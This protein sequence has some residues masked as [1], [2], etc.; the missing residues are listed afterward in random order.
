[1]V[2]DKLSTRRNLYEGLGYPSIN[3]STPDPPKHQ[4]YQCR[5]SWKSKPN[6]PR[7][8]N[9]GDIFLWN[10]QTMVVVGSCPGSMTMYMLFL[11]GY[12]LATFEFCDML[13]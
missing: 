8:E 13:F 6:G 1:M 4:P 9:V 12:Y 7:L 11:I 3:Y 10:V 5:R 2:P